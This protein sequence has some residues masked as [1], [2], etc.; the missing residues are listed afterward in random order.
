MKRMH[1][2]LSG[3]FRT[4]IFLL[5][6]LFAGA[7]GTPLYVSKQTGEK[8]TYSGSYDKTTDKYE[9]GTVTL[10][11]E[12][13]INY[14]VDPEDL[15]IGTEE[16]KS[17]TGQI[18]PDTENAPEPGG[19]VQANLVV[20]YD[21]NYSRPE[22]SGGGGTVVSTYEC[23]PHAKKGCATHAE[24][25]THEL[26][27]EVDKQY[28]PF[29]VISIKVDISGPATVCKG[30]TVE[31]TA[32]AYPGT[33]TVTWSNGTTGNSATYVITEPVT[34][35][36]TYEI[37]GV[38]F[39]DSISVN[40]TGGSPWVFGVGVPSFE[41]WTKQLTKVEKIKATT[42][43]VLS[44]APGSIEVTG[45][46]I[47][48]SYEQR[49]CC[50]DGVPK[51]NGEKKVTG[52]ITGGIY[53]KDIPC[54]SPPWTAQIEL[55]KQMYGYV[56]SISFKYGLFLNAGAELA[57]SIGYK[58]N[59]CKG[60]DCFTGSIGLNFP[61]SFTL[62]GGGSIC[63]QSANASAGMCKGTNQDGSACGNST[64]NNCGYCYQ[65]TSQSWWCFTC[66]SFEVAPAA[67]SSNLYGSVTYNEESCD[68]GFKASAGIGPVI[69]TTGASVLGYT[70]SW[71]YEIWKGMEFYP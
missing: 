69:F 11:T 45:P 34:V 50:A 16:S 58:V 6:P 26:V 23:S 21:I 12:G 29:D 65:H 47:G 55:N 30:D 38:T 70:F 52:T 27:N 41:G 15:S 32:S 40:V 19:T 48:F 31:Y 36:A 13:P 18:S 60:E 4:L 20:N 42:K 67:I 1:T 57:G 61:I 33:G 66:P 71:S 43:V 49:D 28:V 64:K 25:G 8:T 59:E 56:F 10:T 39:S 2:H 7:Q 37:E 14:S 68:A 46:T 17:W 22:G 9:S 44:K 3:L 63:L 62:K 35:S 5:L 51:E 53:A 24:N 54:A